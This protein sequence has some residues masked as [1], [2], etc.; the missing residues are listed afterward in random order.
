MRSFNGNGV[1]FLLFLVAFSACKSSIKEQSDKVYSR[2]LQRHVDLTIIS[3]RMPEEKSD[4]NLLLFNSGNELEQMNAKEIIDSLNRK[5]LIQPLVFV[6]I[7]GNEK[8]DYGM[9]NLAG[10]KNKGNKADKFNEFVMDELYPLIKKKTVVR[11]FNSIAICGNSLAGIS[12]FDIAWQNAD[13][14]DKVGVFSGDFDYAGKQDVNSDQPNAVLQ[15]ISSS[16]KRPK[17]AY[18]FYAAENADSSILNNTKEL[19]DIIDK[20]NNGSKTDIQFITDK[21]GNNDIHSWRHHFAEFLLWA[22]GK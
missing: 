17:L 22:Y 18:W 3:T 20:K 9:S 11:K 4:M 6:A 15:E 12:A 7:H 19:I 1:Y 16:R 14:I 13:K 10:S 2:H 21:T 5:K 8:E